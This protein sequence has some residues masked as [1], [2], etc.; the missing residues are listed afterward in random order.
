MYLSH[1]QVVKP[2]PKVSGSWYQ[3]SYT[4]G[5]WRFTVHPSTCWLY[6][7]YPF[8]KRFVN[9]KWWSLMVTEPL[10]APMCFQII[11]LQ[12]PK[13]S[14]EI[15]SDSREWKN[16]CQESCC[17]PLPWNVYSLSWSERTD[18]PN[19]CSAA[20]W[21]AML[22]FI[23]GETRRKDRQLKGMLQLTRCYEK[24]KG[25]KNAKLLH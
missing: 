5:I 18:L 7:S 22:I 9:Y 21:H 1:G 14:Q 20:A 15:H 11:Y 2:N 23:N 3:T 19:F 25:I 16:P 12:K 17:Q 4:A 10:D 24:E 13:I 8:T 6:Q